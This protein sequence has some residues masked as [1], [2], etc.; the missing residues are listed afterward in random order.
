MRPM[1]LLYNIWSNRANLIGIQFVTR[2]SLIDIIKKADII[3]ISQNLAGLLQ[4]F[5]HLGFI[6][7]FL[8]LKIGYTKNQLQRPLHFEAIRKELGMER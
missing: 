6:P 4:N 7:V 3:Q 8:T 1:I 2:T 5:H